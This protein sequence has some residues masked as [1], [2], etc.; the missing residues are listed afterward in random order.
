M[1][2]SV[3]S[4]IIPYLEDNNKLI[5]TL[6][7]VFKQKNFKMSDFDVIVV[8]SSKNKSSK[9]AIHSF[10]SIYYGLPLRRYFQQ[11]LL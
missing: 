3:I 8:D 9:E 4:V 10:S 1:G 2:N 5:Y 11:K 7:S 6:S